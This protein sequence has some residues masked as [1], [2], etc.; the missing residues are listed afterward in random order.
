MKRGTKSS[1]SSDQVDDLRPRTSF[2]GRAAELERLEALLSAAPPLPVS[3]VGSPGCGKTRLALEYARRAQASG[4]EVASAELSLAVGLRDL[5]HHM[6]LAL[7]VDLSAVDELEEVEQRLL[8]VLAKRGRLLFVLDNCE[9]LVEELA[10]LLER[11]RAGAPEVRFLLT[12]RQRLDLDDELLFELDCLALPSEGAQAG[13]VV[14]DAVELFLDRAR[15]K[16]PGYELDAREAPLVARIL[17]ALDGNPLAIELCA[18]RMSLLGAAE[19]SRNLSDRLRILRSRRQRSGQRWSSLEAAI[20]WSWELLDGEEQ[21]LLAKLSVFRGGFTIDAVE[22]VCP[23]GEERSTIDLLEALRERSL[24][25]ELEA[26][27]AL[28]GARR[29]GL[30]ECVR[31]FA[32]ARL[33]ELG[34]GEESR[35]RHERYYLELLGPSPDGRHIGGG[36]AIRAQLLAERGNLLAIHRRAM[37]ARRGEGALRALLALA[38]INCTRGPFKPYFEQIARAERLAREQGMTEA[39][40]I[41]AALIAKASIESRLCRFEEA[42][43]HLEEA[44]PVVR[45][46]AA[47]WVEAYVLIALGGLLPFLYRADEVKGVFEKARKLVGALDDDRL[48]AIFFKELASYLTWTAPD[49]AERFLGKSLLLFRLT[50]DKVRQAYVLTHLSACRYASGKLDEAER[51]GQRALELLLQLGDRRWSAQ[52]RVVLALVDFERGRLEEAEGAIRQALEVQQEVG[53]AWLEAFA[54]LALSE[55]QMARGDFDGARSGLLRVLEIAGALDE[56]I[57]TTWT[58]AALGAAAAWMG[59][60]DDAE[61]YLGDAEALAQRLADELLILGVELRR[62][63]VEVARSEAAAAGGDLASATRWLDSARARLRRREQEGALRRRAQARLPLRALG[64]AVEGAI[65]AQVEGLQIG[66]EARWFSL[67]GAEGSCEVSLARRETLRKVLLGLVE[68][69][70]R[71]PGEGLSLAELF[72]AGW[73]GESASADSAANRVYV[74]LTRLRRLGLEAL[75][76]SSDEG[77]FLD[78]GVPMKRVK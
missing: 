32:S 49:E 54:L 15:A 46:A 68:A 28:D 7:D 8:R 67:A 4:E 33:D 35:R 61:D 74:T 40:L 69:R 27:Q 56:R 50:M 31:D 1:R 14:G 45:R 65:A 37:A 75:I 51:A 47:P 76:K 19:L 77:F 59:D 10:A 64:R 57:M 23:A 38:P 66:E 17:R 29:L 20:R 60:L 44:L 36:E 22:A 43:R 18:A 52:A 58:L 26:R 9:H 72:E 11:L 24:I 78:P 55:L 42:C 5:L 39:V 30:S 53:N 21:R 70:E 13:D 62:G 3:I 25:E 73:P 16:R 41:A 48:R 2:V 63:C 12:S 6:A 71:R 34:E